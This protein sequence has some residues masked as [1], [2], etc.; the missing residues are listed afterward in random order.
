MRVLQQILLPTLLIA[1]NKVS[2]QLQ[3][4]SPKSATD[5]ISVTETLVGIEQINQ[6]YFA[7]AMRENEAQPLIA[8]MEKKRKINKV[9]YK[10]AR[11]PDKLCFCFAVRLC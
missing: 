11:L 5:I 2:E 10:Q 1:K 8:A 3:K 9:M 7:C 6:C 4:W